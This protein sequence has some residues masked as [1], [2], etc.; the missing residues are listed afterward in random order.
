MS[1]PPFEHEELEAIVGL[2]NG[3]PLPLSALLRGTRPL[4][5]EV[6][7]LLAVVLDA[8][9][10]SKW[11]FV[12][13][14]RSA[15]CPPTGSEKFPSAMIAR[16]CNGAD[17]EP[18]DRH[19]LAAMIDPHGDSEWKLRLEK[20]KGRQRLS[21]EETAISAIERARAISDYVEALVLQGWSR[22]K[23]YKKA[24]AHL[25]ISDKSVRDAVSLIDVYRG[26][27]PKRAAKAL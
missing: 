23:A 19:K 8:R 17:V 5:P 11:R 16:L 22:K 26:A 10:A 20:R 14:R 9:G 6:Q 25:K 2:N 1:E 13:G 4:H 12:H 3:D 7:N 18:S 21:M 24:A 27:E 15:G